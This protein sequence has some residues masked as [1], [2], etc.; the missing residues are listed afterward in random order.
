MTTITDDD[1]RIEKNG[2]GQETM[3]FDPLQSAK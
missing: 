3:I 2:D 1:I